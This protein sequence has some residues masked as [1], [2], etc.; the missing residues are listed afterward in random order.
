MESRFQLFRDCFFKLGVIIITY[1]NYFKIKYPKEK[2]P[3]G[4]GINLTSAVKIGKGDT[5]NGKAKM[6]TADLR[7][8][9]REVL[10]TTGGTGVLQ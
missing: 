10:D 7:Q 4:Y 5:T 1:V 2:P 8:M 3:A 9:W 6:V